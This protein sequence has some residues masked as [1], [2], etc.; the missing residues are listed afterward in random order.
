MQGQKL[1]KSSLNSK[2]LKHLDKHFSA[3]A[4][5]ISHFHISFLEKG[6]KKSS[7]VVCREKDGECR[8]VRERKKSYLS[9]RPR[10]C[11][12]IST[13]FFFEKVHFINC[14]FF[15]SMC[16]LSRAQCNKLCS[17]EGREK[18]TKNGI[19]QTVL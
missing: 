15:S 17:V 8:R 18:H 4:T 7:R 6:E 2:A 12:A 16:T 1:D 14:L 13:F 19:A 3:D 5:H 9:K 10:K 11:V